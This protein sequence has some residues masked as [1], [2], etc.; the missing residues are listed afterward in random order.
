MCVPFC[1]SLGVQVQ[2]CPLSPQACLN[3]GMCLIRHVFTSQWSFCVAFQQ[4]T[5]CMQA[6]PSATDQTCWVTCAST[7]PMSSPFVGRSCL[8]LRSSAQPRSPARPCSAWRASSGRL[9][10][11]AMQVIYLCAHKAVCK[12]CD[13]MD[14]CVCAYLAGA[15]AFFIACSHT[16][17]LTELR[18]S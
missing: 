2:P 4:G 18:M 1:I 8:Q 12:M 13:L 11:G 17:C 6:S 3:L 15:W 9:P 10:L 14:A 16:S 7:N 5:S